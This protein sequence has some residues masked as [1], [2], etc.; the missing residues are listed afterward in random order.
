M[1]MR[2][3]KPMSQKW[4]T[5]TE[6]ARYVGQSAM[7]VGAIMKEKGWRMPNGHGQPTQDAIELNQA[8]RFRS[9]VHPEF[10]KWNSQLLA[11]MLIDVL[12]DTQSVRFSKEIEKFGKLFQQMPTSF[13]KLGKEG[14]KS[15]YK[16]V[17]RNADLLV[18]QLERALRPRTPNA[19][20]YMIGSLRDYLHA[21]QVEIDGFNDYLLEASGFQDAQKLWAAYDKVVLSHAT[22]TCGIVT[23]PRK[24]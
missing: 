13:Y 2:A 16:D 19:R 17:L 14:Y 1:V 9:H 11:P 7:T 24:L 15:S 3:L 21:N 22:K 12:S 6:A 20:A 18:S 10:Y 8:K 4:V 5:I 23:K